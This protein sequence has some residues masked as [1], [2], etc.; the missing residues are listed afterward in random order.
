MYSTGRK[1]GEQPSGVFRALVFL[2]WSLTEN[3]V[4][5]T[6]HRVQTQGA[7]E[8]IAAW[9]DQALHP[10]QGYELCPTTNH[11]SRSYGRPT[12]CATGA[13]CARASRGSIS[14]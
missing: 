4:L 7:H 1:T 11:K 13:S 5:K 2:G 9:T 10:Q 8:Q 3:N 14:A 6:T 12:R